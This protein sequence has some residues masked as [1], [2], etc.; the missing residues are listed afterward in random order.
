MIECKCPFVWYC[1]R[2][3]KLSGKKQVKLL[4]LIQ[5]RIDS[6]KFKTTKDLADCGSLRLALT[7]NGMEKVYRL[8]CRKADIV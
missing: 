2:A 3:E 5:K 1:R 4:N 7:F 6:G 8:G